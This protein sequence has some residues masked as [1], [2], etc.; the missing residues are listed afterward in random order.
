MERPSH[1]CQRQIG[2]LPLIVDQETIRALPQAEQRN[3]PEGAAI[4]IFHKHQR[5]VGCR[6]T[7]LTQTDLNVIQ[8]IPQCYVRSGHDADVAMTVGIEKA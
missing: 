1:N 2:C 5:V 4:D 7:C 8:P 6:N 3:K